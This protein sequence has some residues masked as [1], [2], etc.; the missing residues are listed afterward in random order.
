MFDKEPTKANENDLHLK[1]IDYGLIREFDSDQL[2]QDF[3]H[4]AEAI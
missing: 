4:F 3:L 1:L 2:N